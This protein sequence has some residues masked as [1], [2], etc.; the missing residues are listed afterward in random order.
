VCVDENVCM[1]MWVWDRALVK[2][3]YVPLSRRIKSERSL[4]CRICFVGVRPN[5]SEGSLRTSIIGLN[6]D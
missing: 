4:N 6:V 1:W 3:A 5:F 2:V